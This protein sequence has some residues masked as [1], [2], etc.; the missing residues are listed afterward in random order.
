MQFFK[1]KVRRRKSIWRRLNEFGDSFLGRVVVVLI[2]IA[3]SA[4]ISILTY[5]NRQDELE[6][7]TVEKLIN[8]ALDDIKSDTTE[9]VRLKLRSDM[10]FRFIKE[11]E[12][13]DIVAV[14]ESNESIS[15]GEIQHKQELK[16]VVSYHFYKLLQEYRFYPN[17]NNIERVR[18]SLDERIPQYDTLLANLDHITFLENRHNQFVEE[19]EKGLWTEGLFSKHWHHV[20]PIYEA[21]SVSA[22][23]NISSDSI[24]FLIPGSVVFTDSSMLEIAESRY[25]QAIW[26]RSFL[27]LQELSKLYAKTKSNLC[28][29]QKHLDSEKRKSRS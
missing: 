25:A 4:I 6:N 7:A 16:K 5:Q 21:D 28:V 23:G 24:P 1:R 29:I 8:L 3:I 27:R 20:L 15:K 10:L 12:L 11:H 22:G 9:I 19:M 14:L 13:N 26:Y 18:N 17:V 2:S